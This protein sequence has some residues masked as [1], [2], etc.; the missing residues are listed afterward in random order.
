MPRLLAAA[1]EP[2]RERA[3]EKDH[4]LRAQRTVLRGPE[5]ENVDAALP[6]RLRRRAAE[7]RQCVRE[8]RA[9]HVHVEPVPFGRRRECRQLLETVHRAE[10]RGLCDAHRGG[11]HVMHAHLLGECHGGGERLGPDLP[12]GRG[13]CEQLRPS[14]E[15]FRRAAFVRDD[16]RTRM[17]IDAAVGRRDLRQGQRVG[18][19]AGGNGVD[20]DLRL[21][22]IRGHAGQALGEGIRAVRARRGGVRRLNRRQD[23]RAHRGDVVATKIAGQCICHRLTS[24]RI[25]PAACYRS[26]PCSSRPRTGADSPDRRAAHATGASYRTKG[27]CP[28]PG[29]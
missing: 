13:Q 22:Q 21:E 12:R 11:T 17:A 7:A 9:V 16:V 19:R 24:P 23:G 2:F 18:R 10:L 3:I 8:S 28:G 4:G 20:Q 15:E 26:L 14:R 6:G 1:L 25:A 27:Q 29:A 5:R